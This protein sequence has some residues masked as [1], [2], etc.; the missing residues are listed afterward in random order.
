MSAALSFEGSVAP[1]STT[2]ASFSFV[3][4][5]AELVGFLHPDRLKPDDKAQKV[6][7]DARKFICE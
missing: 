5:A 4:C 1:S 6:I 7:M 2:M 3:V